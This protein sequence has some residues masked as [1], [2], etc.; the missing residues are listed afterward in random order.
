MLNVQA[1]KILQLIVDEKL[2][3][4]SAFRQIVQ[5]YRLLKLAPGGKTFFYKEESEIIV[6]PAIYPKGIET[7]MIEA[8]KKNP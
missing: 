5:N 4:D 6:A 7:E 2:C 3:E 1:E 8:L